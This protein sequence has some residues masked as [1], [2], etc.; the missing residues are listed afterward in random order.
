MASVTPAPAEAK[1]AQDTAP[2]SGLAENLTYLTPDFAVAPALSAEDF[3]EAARL[4]FKAIINNRPD[5]EQDGQSTAAELSPE[6]LRSGLSYAHVPANKLE[7]FCDDVVGGMIGAM[8][9]AEGPILAHCQSGMRSAIVWAAATSRNRPVDDVLE[10]LDKAGF[11]LDFLRDEL[12]QQANHAD[13]IATIPSAPSAEPG[14]I[15]TWDSVR[16]AIKRQLPKFITG[17]NAEPGQP[18]GATEAA[19]ARQTRD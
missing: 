14:P 8:K 11:E 13:A 6:A 10:I 19:S 5:G 17:A 1:L 18:A 3:A 2:K 15:S 4:G 7:L 12:D 9:S 16:G